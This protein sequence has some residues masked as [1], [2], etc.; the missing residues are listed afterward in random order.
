MWGGNWSNIETYEVIHERDIIKNKFCLDNNYT[1]IRIP[2]SKINN[3][4]IEDIMEDKYKIY[5]S[6]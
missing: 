1:L 2:Y 6:E 3:L 4:T 5:E